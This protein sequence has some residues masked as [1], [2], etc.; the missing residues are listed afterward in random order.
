MW[1][2]IDPFTYKPDVLPLGS[3][4]SISVRHLAE[5]GDHITDAGVKSRCAVFGPSISGPD[6]RRKPEFVILAQGFSP[7]MNVLYI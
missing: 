4:L 2:R 1:R 3:Y 7:L 5:S 6:L